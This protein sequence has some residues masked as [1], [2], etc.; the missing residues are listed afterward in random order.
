MVSNTTIIRAYSGSWADFNNTPGQTTMAGWGTEEDAERLSRLNPDRIF[1]TIQ[2][3][4]W[5]SAYH[6]GYLLSRPEFH[7]G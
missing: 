1:L 3:G 4:D 2:S 7:N 5:L 6:R